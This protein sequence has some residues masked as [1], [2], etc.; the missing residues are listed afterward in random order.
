MDIPSTY[1]LRPRLAYD[2]LKNISYRNIGCFVLG[3]AVKLAAF[4]KSKGWT[5]A[6]LGS[7]LGCSQAYVSQIER[8]TDPL[9][10]GPE[11]MGRIFEVS[12]GAV[13][14]NDFYQLPALEAAREAA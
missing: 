1:K 10:P 12:E 5:Q 4:R 14:P 11:L 9:I 7:R 6:E 8:A 3:R 13:E 2:Q